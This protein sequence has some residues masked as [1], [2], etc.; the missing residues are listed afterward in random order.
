MIK[1]TQDQIILVTGASSGIGRQT[2]LLLN[3]L[4]ASVIGLGRDEGRLAALKES[5]TNPDQMWTVSRDLTED[6]HELPEF[7]L[8]LAQKHGK[9]YGVVYSSGIGCICPLRALD[10]ENM[11]NLFNVNYFAAVLMAKGFVNRNVHMGVGSSFVN[12]ASISFTC[13]NTGLLAYSGSKAAMV[14]SFK[15]IAMEYVGKGIRFNCISPSDI[16]TPLWETN[17][18]LMEQTEKKYPLGF[19]KPEDVAPMAAY[20]LS[21]VSRWVTGQNFVLDCASK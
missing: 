20:L 18:T 9:I 1:F 5:A 13:T 8:E 17:S 14:T 11:I 2:A 15:S 21:P 3:S 10:Y 7:M 16:K 12:I 6:I 4:G 19:G